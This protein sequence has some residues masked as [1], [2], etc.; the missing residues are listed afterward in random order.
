MKPVIGSFKEYALM[1]V[2]DTFGESEIWS[3]AAGI[4]FDR[5]N[6]DYTCSIGLSDL[7]KIE[8]QTGLS[9]SNILFPILN[10][11]SDSNIGLM[12]REFYRLDDSNQKHSIDFDSVKMFALDITNSEWPNDLSIRWKLSDSKERMNG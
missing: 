9:V 5:F 3:K 2:R 8:R 11:L 12:R 7:E 1:I 4:L 10:L 6:L